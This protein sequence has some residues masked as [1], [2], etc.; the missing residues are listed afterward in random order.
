VKHFKRRQTAA[1]AAA[2]RQ[3]AEPSWRGQ[4]LLSAIM[5]SWPLRGDG[6]VAVVSGADAI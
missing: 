4:G 2:A 6:F 5:S 3:P 1:C